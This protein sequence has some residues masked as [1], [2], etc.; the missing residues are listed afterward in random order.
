MRVG[1]F[2]ALVFIRGRGILGYQNHSE[3]GDETMRDFIKVSWSHAFPIAS[4]Q[5]DP[6]KIPNEPGIYIIQCGRKINRLSGFD[7]AGILY[8]G[9]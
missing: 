4:V 6:D 3:K 9:K 2:C 1:E 5:S 8:F 7:P